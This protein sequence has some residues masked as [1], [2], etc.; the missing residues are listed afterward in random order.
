[1]KRILVT[2]SRDWWSMAIIEHAL[3]ETL[4]DLVG[5]VSRVRSEVVLVSGACPS[6]ADFLTERIATRKF[7]MRVERHPAKWGQYGNYAG[8]KR[9]EEMVNLGADICL[10]FIM[11]NSPGATHCLGL[12]KAAEIPTAV[13]RARR[14]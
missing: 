6:G 11:N 9:N 7:K 8:F 4:S 2:G 13:Y 14:N 3:F 12:A 1:M 10:A 5:K